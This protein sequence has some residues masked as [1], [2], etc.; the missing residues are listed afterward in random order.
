MPGGPLAPRA[1][2]G[3][4]G[5]ARAQAVHAA[6]GGRERLRVRLRGVVRVTVQYLRWNIQYI[7][8]ID[9]MQGLLASWDAL[10]TEQLYSQ[11]PRHYD[12]SRGSPSNFGNFSY[13]IRSVRVRS[14]Y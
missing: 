4:R 6:R 13:K 8:N 12:I 10:R 2:G 7:V 9:V 5:G 14:G 11:A 3:R 1:P